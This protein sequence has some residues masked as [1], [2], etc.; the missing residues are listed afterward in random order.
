MLRR[1]SEV[2]RHYES[3]TQVRGAHEEHLIPRQGVCQVVRL[4]IE[5]KT[6]RGSAEIIRMDTVPIFCF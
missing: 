2:R 6:S 3:I 4:T 5:R 1:I